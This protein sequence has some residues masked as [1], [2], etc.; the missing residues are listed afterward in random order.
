L[1]IYSSF[2]L[3][4]I[5][6]ERNPRKREKRKKEKLQRKEKSNNLAINKKLHWSFEAKNRQDIF[7]T[8]FQLRQ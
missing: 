3:K 6:D 2:Y 1:S 4:E 8:G 7:L 5:K